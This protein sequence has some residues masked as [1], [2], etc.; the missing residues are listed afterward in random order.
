MDRFA[1]AA[2]APGR[3][4]VF[5]AVVPHTVLSPNATITRG[6]SFVISGPSTTS[7]TF[8]GGTITLT[9]SP[10]GCRNETYA[11]RGQLSTSR[12]PGSFDVTL[13]HFRTPASGRCISY[14][15]S[16]VGQATVPQ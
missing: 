2:T 1:G 13:T 14:F 11:V 7:G 6:G 8:T 3:R 10:S 4:A 16:M 15:A 9:S 12:G 5:N